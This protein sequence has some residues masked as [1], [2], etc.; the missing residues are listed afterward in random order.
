MW[1]K[2][3]IPSINLTPNRYNALAPGIVYVNNYITIPINSMTSQMSTI[4][5]QRSLLWVCVNGA[6]IILK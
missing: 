1:I 4:A 6:E 5:T 2:V 3:E